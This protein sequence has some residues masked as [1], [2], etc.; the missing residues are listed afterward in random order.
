MAQFL[1]G[2]PSTVQSWLHEVIEH[3]EALRFPMQESST[4]SKNGHSAELSVHTILPEARHPFLPTCNQHKHDGVEY[5]YLL[6]LLDEH[7]WSSLR[8]WH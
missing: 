8:G 1:L 3:K 6:L 5:G 7:A 2:I 4:S